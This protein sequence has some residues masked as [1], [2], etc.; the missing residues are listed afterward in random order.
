MKSGVIKYL[1][2]LIL[3]LTLVA[4][5]DDDTGTN[6]PDN[7]EPENKVGIEM[8]RIEPG[9]YTRGDDV[10]T[11]AQPK[12]LVTITKAF[13]IGKYELLG[14]EYN[15]VMGEGADYYESERHP[16]D[17][18]NWYDAVEF[19]NKLSEYEGLTPVYTIDGEDVSWDQNADGYRLP[20]E[21]EWEL[22]CRAGTSTSLYNGEMPRIDFSPHTHP[23]LDEI[24]WYG[25][26]TG[27]AYQ[28]GLKKPNQFGLY[29]MIGNL[30]EW[31]WD[32]AASYSS[33][34]K[35]DPMGPE[36]GRRKIAKG[37]SYAAEPNIARCGTRYEVSPAGTGL[38]ATFRV[39]RNVAN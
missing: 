21:A 39:A 10:D 14:S 1:T 16:L 24:A 31:C 35:V 18:V 9:T 38:G 23:L 13:W 3:V 6:P 19:C 32:W 5:S 17:S 22:A 7:N 2:A 27:V 25:E 30:A 12:H 36:N 8:V 15:K 29:D 33:S 4:C 28:V 26:R 20:T 37:G 11:Y 34:A